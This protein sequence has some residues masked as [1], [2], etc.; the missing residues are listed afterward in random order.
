MSRLFAGDIASGVEL[1]GMHMP[2][3]IQSTFK[4]IESGYHNCMF[5]ELIPNGFLFFFLFYTV[6]FPIRA[7]ENVGS[8]NTKTI[9]LVLNSHSSLHVR[10]MYTHLIP[11]LYSKTG[12][13]RDIQFFLFLIQNIHCGYPLEPPWQGGSYVYPQCV[14]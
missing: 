8:E 10:E 9:S 14:F 12:I 7:I 5:W 1:M 13:Y 4:T 3:L 6:C 2:A 11:L